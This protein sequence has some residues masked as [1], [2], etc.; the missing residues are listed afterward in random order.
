M[1][2]WLFIY[3]FSNSWNSYSIYLGGAPNKIE[4]K[5]EYNNMFRI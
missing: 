1:T 3:L 2:S 4:N 5:T